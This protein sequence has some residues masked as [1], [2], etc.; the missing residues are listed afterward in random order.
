MRFLLLILFLCPHNLKK[1][2]Y[3]L[4]QRISH[5]PDKEL[6]GLKVTCTVARSS[7]SS[8]CFT[9]MGP[10]TAAITEVAPI[11]YWAEPSALFRR[12]LSEVTGLS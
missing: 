5:I 11:E 3:P 2:Y 1:E 10:Y 8:R 4:T 7:I 6:F 9:S 12:P